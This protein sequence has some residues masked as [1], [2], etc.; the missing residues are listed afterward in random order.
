MLCAV[1]GVHWTMSQAASASFQRTAIDA[2]G[3]GGNRSRFRSWWNLQNVMGW[4]QWWWVQART[5]MQIQDFGQVHTWRSVSWSDNT[6]MMHFCNFSL[7]PLCGTEAL[8]RSHVIECPMIPCNHGTL[9]TY[10]MLVLIWTVHQRTIRPHMG[11]GGKPTGT[12]F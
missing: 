10:L 2:G 3:R 11:M 6:R 5:P 4:T 7:G 1:R 8:K 12:M 9:S